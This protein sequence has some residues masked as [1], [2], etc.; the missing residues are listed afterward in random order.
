MISLAAR[1]MGHVTGRG[2]VAQVV[3]STMSVMQDSWRMV[4]MSSA[5][6]GLPF[7]TVVVMAISLAGSRDVQ[8]AVVTVASL[9][10]VAV[11]VGHEA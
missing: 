10:P 9:P 1:H 5:T 6:A 11:S 4:T 7:W 3:P 2:L 8:V